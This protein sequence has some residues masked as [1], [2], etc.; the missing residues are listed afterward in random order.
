MAR[1]VGGLVGRHGL[2]HDTGAHHG[3][4]VGPGPHA[5]HRRC[6]PPWV[7]AWR[8]S[9]RSSPGSCSQ[10]FA[11]GSVFLVTVPLALLALYMAS[12]HVPAHVNEATEP[13]DN[14]GGVLSAIMIGALVVALNFITVPNLQALAIGLLVVA[15]IVLVAVRHAPEAS[16]E[17]AVRPGDRR[18]QA[19]SG[20]PPW[21]ASSSSAR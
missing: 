11:W 21:P 2:S 6:G 15:A 3:A 9:G 13:V 19:R 1:V 17:P 14:I 7:A 20:W 16:R 10:Y 18:S 8:C 5:L 4:L 12:K